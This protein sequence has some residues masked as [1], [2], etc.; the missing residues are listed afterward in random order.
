[1][2][3]GKRPELNKEEEAEEVELRGIREPGSFRVKSASSGGS[4]DVGCGPAG[5]AQKNPSE[6]VLIVVAH[7]TN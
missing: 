4:P 5:M 3:L 6:H 2:K 1:M 7:L